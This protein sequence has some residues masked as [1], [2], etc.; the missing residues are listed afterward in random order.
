MMR[1]RALWAIC[2]MTLGLAASPAHAAFTC[3]TVATRGDLDPD[4]LPF[5][6]FFR[7]PVAVN[8]SGDVLFVGQATG[9]KKKVYYYQNGGGATVLA[10]AGAAGPG[11]L[12]YRSGNAFDELGSNEFDDV[13]LRAGVKGGEAVVGRAG[14]GLLTTYAATGDA[15]P[16]GGLFDG[17]PA[18]SSRLNGGGFGAFVGR[19]DDGS[20]GVVQVDL[21][22]STLTCPMKK[23]DTIDGRF[24]CQILDVG[25]G[26]GFGDF[27]ARATTVPAGG[28]CGADPL[29]ETI[30]T[31]TDVVALAGDASSIAGTTY[32]G[33]VGEPSV[34]GSD[35]SFHANLTGGSV[36]A[37]VFVA[38][39]PAAPTT[40][41]A[42]GDAVPDVG[43]T[44][45]RLN[46]HWLTSAGVF[47]NAFVRDA[48]AR[49]GFFSSG[50][51]ALTEVD[52]PPFGAEY[53]R[54]SKKPQSG[55]SPDGAYLATRVRIKDT[56]SPKKKDTIIRCEPVTCASVGGVEVGGACWFLGAGGASCDDACGAIGGVYDE[57]TRT[58]AGS[59]GTTANCESVL[60]ALPYAGTPPGTISCGAA[61]GLGCHINT[62]SANSS[63]R[64][65]ETTTS[66]ASSSSIIARAC[67]CSGF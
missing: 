47:V 61:F 18:V 52:A 42:A 21:I 25:Y 33:F 43:G 7:A 13:L 10:T 63:G 40:A 46:D 9:S 55:M 1:H 14:G 31:A 27:A 56:V 35:V 5:R 60:D 34:L 30:L 15:S 20:T 64:C 49:T 65:T 19:A 8:E 45:K 51:A 67:A 38:T 37:A 50:E 58:F 41:I 29:L 44:F 28:D 48:T 24:V 3:E 2:A 54:F 36:D 32:A 16:C 62:T 39:P 23:G 6:N 4:G 11:G 22:L 57:A 12:V 66:T 53:R 59:D 26:S 17:F